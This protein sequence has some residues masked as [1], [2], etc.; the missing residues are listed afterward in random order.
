MKKLFLLI[1]A[2]VLAIAMNAKEIEIEQAKYDA[3]AD[4]TDGLVKLTEELGESD[5]SFARASK[6]LA[7][8]TIAIRTGEAIAKMVSMESGKGVAGLATMA[9]GIAT[10]LTNIASAI[11]MV[12]SAKFA[13]GGAVNGRGSSTSDSNTIRVSD[14]E[15][16]INARST[17][18]FAPLL[19]QLNQLGGGVPIEVV[20]GNT[21]QIGEDMLATAFAKGAS[22]LPNPV[23]SV[24]EIRDVSRRVDVLEQLAKI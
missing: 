24:E 20:T 10:I 6:V 1:P 17:Q 14:G 18:M 2:L 7:L 16:V 9:G 11:K 4:I 15:S 19:S 23:V 13:R 5:E 22:M 3:M 8:A 12:R 21:N